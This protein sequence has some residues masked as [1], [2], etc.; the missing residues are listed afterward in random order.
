MRNLYKFIFFK[1]FGWSISG[2]VPRN[3]NKF[4][5][6]VAP[7]SS[8]IDFFVGLFVRAILKFNCG[9]L[10][11]KELF[12]FPFG[13]LFRALGGYPVDRK[14]SNKLVDQVVTIVKKEERFA[15]AI[16]PEGTRKPVKKWK[17]GF[18]YI[19]LQ[20]NIPLVM[21]SFDYERKNVKFS[22]PFYLTGIT[23]TDAKA[24]NDYFKNT[25]GKNHNAAPLVLE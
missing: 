10:A 16:A 22:E 13:I 9:F 25:N 1:I 18:Y 14:S 17:T 6:I 20:A 8:S 12:N 11:K 15:V 21:A 23:I 4:I 3:I 5:I 7:H 24:I 2:D 19:A